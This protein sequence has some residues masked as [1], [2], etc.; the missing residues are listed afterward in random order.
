MLV[1]LLKVGGVTALAVGVFY[2]LY[3][4]MVDSGHFRKMSSGQTFLF[5]SLVAV[6]TFLVVVLVAGGPVALVS[7]SGVV[8]N[9]GL[10]Q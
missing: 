1:E 9:Q 6:L 4:K 10:T 5:F 2:L 8:V 3:A 7:G